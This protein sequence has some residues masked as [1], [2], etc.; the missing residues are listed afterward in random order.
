MDCSKSV[1]K[2]AEE[3]VIL[4]SRLNYTQYSVIIYI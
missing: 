4:N 2:E 1:Y 3:K